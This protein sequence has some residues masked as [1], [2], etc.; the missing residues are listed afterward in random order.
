[1]PWFLQMLGFGVLLLGIGVALWVSL[2]L[3]VILF[4][5]G[6]GMVVLSHVRAYLTAKGV[7]NPKPGVRPEAPD[8]VTIVEG[9]FERID[10]QENAV[11]PDDRDD[12]PQG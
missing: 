10:L 1:M 5:I 11:Q 6:V 7:L 3:L 9:D 2:W 8:G 4:A 12:H